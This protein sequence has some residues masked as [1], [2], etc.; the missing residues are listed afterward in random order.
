MMMAWHFLKKFTI[1]L[2]L[3]LSLSLSLLCGVQKL[4]F[5]EL[6]T[7]KKKEQQ[8]VVFF[9]WFSRRDLRAGPRQIYG[10]SYVCQPVNRTE[11]LMYT[12]TFVLQC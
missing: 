5:V 10:R 1:F 2:S 12:S 4:F 11:S 8:K 7:K 9:H 3:S 6:E